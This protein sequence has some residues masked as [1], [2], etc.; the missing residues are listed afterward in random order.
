MEVMDNYKL[1]IDEVINKHYGIFIS[2]PNITGVGRGNKIINGNM[3]DI[4]TLTIFVKKKVSISSLASCDIIPKFI[5]GALTDVYQVGLPKLKAGEVRPALGG[6]SI[7]DSKIEGAGTLGYAVTDKKKEKLFILSCAHVIAPSNK[8]DSPAQKI[9]Q[10]ALDDGGTFR[11][12]FM[13][14]VANIIPL[15]YGKAKFVKDANEVDAGIVFVGPYNLKTQTEKLDALLLNKTII[16]GVAEVT[17][18]E[19]VYKIGRS[20][21]I[22]EGKVI[23]VNVTQHSID[24]YNGEVITYIKQIST[25]IRIQG[26]DSGAIGVTKNGNKAFGLLTSGDEEVAVFSDVNRVLKLLDI[27]LA[28][29]LV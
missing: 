9:L 16:S 11:K 8:I 28:Y 6:V 4:P 19:S 17:V 12:S 23:A 13:G 24:D 18:G 15:K 10:P 21:G 5:S 26:G 7:G 3:T 22:T 1:R 20:T 14:V 29:P 27:E 2:N 25:D